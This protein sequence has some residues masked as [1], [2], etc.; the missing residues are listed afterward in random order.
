M[1]RDGE[2]RFFRVVP[3]EYNGGA[4]FRH[5][6]LIVKNVWRNRRRTALTIGSIGVSMCLLGVIITA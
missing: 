2:R 5:V 3:I 1:A 6:S 4:V